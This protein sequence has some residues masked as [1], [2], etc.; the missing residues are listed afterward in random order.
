MSAVSYAA[1][2]AA[3]REGPA[4]SRSNSLSDGNA[5]SDTRPVDPCRIAVA[6]LWTALDHTRRELNEATDQLEQLQA[7][8][9]VYLLR[10]TPANALALRGCCDRLMK[11]QMAE[12]REKNLAE[13]ARVRGRAEDLL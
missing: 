3:E 9:G 1:V 13:R 6:E 5:G 7:A 11:W 10:C 4:V 2:Q 8:A 12:R